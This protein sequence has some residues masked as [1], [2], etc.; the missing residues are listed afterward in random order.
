M[1]PVQIVACGGGTGIG[2]R[3]LRAPAA[4]RKAASSRGRGDDRD[5]GRHWIGRSVVEPSGRDELPGRRG[6]GRCH[7]GKRR[8]PDDFSGGGV[9]LDRQIGGRTGRPLRSGLRTRCSLPSR[10]PSWSSHRGCHAAGPLAPTNSRSAKKSGQ[11]RLDPAFHSCSFKDT[12]TSCKG[13]RHY[14]R[15]HRDRRR[16]SV[17]TSVTD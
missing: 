4:V 17:A 14:R 13:C 1:P 2:P 9:I 16:H 15:R 3:A 7:A 5:R 12:S 8:E 6:G 11:R 10:P